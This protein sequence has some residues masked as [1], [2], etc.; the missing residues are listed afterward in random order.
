MIIGFALIVLFHLYNL[1]SLIT[2]VTVF[3]S[4]NK[5]FIILVSKVMVGY[6]TSS[7]KSIKGDA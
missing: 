1:Y 3:L 2:I 4:W 5:I 6:T 7:H